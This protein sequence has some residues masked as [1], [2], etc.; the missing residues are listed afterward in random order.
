MIETFERS[1][2]SKEA[3]VLDVDE[4]S[5]RDGVVRARLHGIASTPDD[6]E[7]MQAGKQSYSSGTAADEAEEIGQYIADTMEPGVT[8]VV[9][10]GSTTARVAGALGQPKTLLGVDVYRDRVRVLEDATESDI[11]GEL[12]RCGE[13]MVI[14][15][16]IGAQGFF[17]GRG[18]QQVSPRV[19][20]A[21]GLGNI[22]VV[23]TPSKL[24]S[25]PV[26]RVDTGDP[27]LDSELRG[28]VKVVTGYKRRRLVK[29]A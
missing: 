29:V 20:R 8:Y 1:M 14:V 25:T 18:N 9:G 12:G 6:S 17:L 24:A 4:D 27:A 3:E 21:V 13:A 26:L 7:H 11:L 5:F 2:T 15:T 28:G 16:P 22:V 10:P 23:A 19:V